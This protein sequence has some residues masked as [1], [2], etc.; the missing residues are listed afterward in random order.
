MLGGGAGP[1]NSGKWQSNMNFRFNLLTVILLLLLIG[2]VAYFLWAYT[3]AKVKAA[4]LTSDL[5]KSRGDLMVALNKVRKMT[6]DK[7]PTKNLS[8][9]RFLQ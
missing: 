1:A 5:D 6:D 3:P 4:A 7:G 2:A 8:D 9:G